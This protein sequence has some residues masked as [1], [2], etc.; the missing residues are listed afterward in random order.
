MAGD[1]RE[2]CHNPRGSM[3]RPIGQ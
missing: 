3:C 2:R 1:Y